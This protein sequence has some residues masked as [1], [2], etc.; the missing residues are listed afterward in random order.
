LE[1][2]IGTV[3]GNSG[4]RLVASLALL[5]E[6]QTDFDRSIGPKLP[7]SYHA[8]V[9]GMAV[10]S[11]TGSCCRAVLTG[12][13]VIIRDVTA[14][15]QWSRFASFIGP[16]GYRAAWSSLITGSDGRVLG[17]FAVY[18]QHP[19][20]ASAS[21]QQFVQGITRTVGLVIERAR[22]EELLRESE[23]RYRQ[24]ANLLPV[25]VYTCDAEGV[26]TYYNQ[27]AAQL[28]GRAPALGDTDERFCGSEQMVLPNGQVLP[29]DQCPMAVALREGASFREEAVDILR[30]DG[31]RISV[32]VNIDPIKD[33]A[34]RIVGAVN[35]FHD[36]TEL[37]RAEDAQQLLVAELNH[38]VKNTLASVQAIA[39]H[40]MRR[41][42]DPKEFVSSFAGRIQ[43]LSRVHALLSATTWRSA[44]LSELVHDQLSNGAA[45][46]T[47]IIV[48]GPRLQLPPQMALHMAMILHELGT[49]ALKYGALSTPSGWVTVRWTVEDRALHLCWQERG[50]PA[51]FVPTKRGFGM[52]LVEQSAQGEGGTARMVLEGDGIAWDITLPL[53]QLISAENAGQRAARRV[54]TSSRQVAQLAGAPRN[55][56]GS[57]FLIVEDEPLVALDLVDNLVSA[58]AEVVASVGSYKE[59]L[60]IIEQRRIDA[61]LLD[62]NLHGQPVDEIASALTRHNV[63]FVFVTGYGRDS[64]PRAFQHVALVN[65]PFSPPQLLEAAA[66]LLAR[67]A[68]VIRLRKK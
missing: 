28:W 56:T 50:G 1:F 19:E 39:H 68:D 33:N 24:L 3:E 2:L 65:K 8:A 53:P 17:T 10:S 11:D 59:A 45:D 31:T 20:E 13:P 38:R 16:L 30:P 37:R 4:D 66:M 60:E 12:R 26:I 47:R 46:E 15:A 25:A 7:V 40:T 5:N 14:E 58:G 43:S 32:R 54:S 52:T 41:T 51:V 62:G 61:A 49:N 21:D 23:Q 27:Q 34:D 22:T 44:D 18:S 6:K 57:R 67:G 55:L 64:L 63:P 29:H 36:V 9:Q 42:Q 35:V 48:K